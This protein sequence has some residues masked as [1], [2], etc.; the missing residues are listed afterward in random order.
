MKRKIEKDLMFIIESEIRT[1]LCILD[2]VERDVEVNVYLSK[3]LMDRLLE[4]RD[5]KAELVQ[6][7]VLKYKTTDNLLITLYQVDAF[8]ND[9]Y[10]IKL[11]YMKNIKYKYINT[12]A[13]SPFGD[14][15]SFK[16]ARELMGSNDKEFIGSTDDG[17]SSIY[18]INNIYYLSR[19]NDMG[20]YYLTEVELIN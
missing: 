4:Q 19:Y 8:D 15:L 13:S 14:Y 1:D 11:R 16:I 3:N 18:K 12:K 2:K 5:I 20:E 10:D 17:W 9:E 6:P 7:R